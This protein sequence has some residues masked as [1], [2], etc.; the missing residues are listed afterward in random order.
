MFFFTVDLD[1]RQSENLDDSRFENIDANQLENPDANYIPIIQTSSTKYLENEET[2]IEKFLT[3]DAIDKL[4]ST[5]EIKEKTKSSLQTKESFINHMILS[6]LV[7][8]FFSIFLQIIYV[9][10]KENN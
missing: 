5:N 6:L 9:L 8:F 2:S 1:N 10:I 7:S 3:D 4:K